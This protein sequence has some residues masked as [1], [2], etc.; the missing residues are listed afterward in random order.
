MFILLKKYKKYE[1]EY[2]SKTKKLVLYKPIGVREFM[3]LKRDIYSN[4]LDVENIIVTNR[5][6]VAKRQF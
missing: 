5:R 3:E 2:S 1:A 4:N 6:L